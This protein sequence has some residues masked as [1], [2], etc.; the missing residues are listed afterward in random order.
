MHYNSHLKNLVSALPHEPGIYQY[1]DKDGTIIYIGK[2][3]DLKKRVS[4]YFTKTHD[5]RKTA[6]LVRNIIDIKTIVVETEQ[7]A[8]I[9]ENNLIKKYKPRYNIM[10][11]DDKTY[12]WIC[13]KNESF[14]RVFQTRRIERD[15]SLYFGPFTSVMLVR[16]L[17]ELFRQSYKLRNC[18]LQLSEANVS[19]GKFKV[20]LQ[21]HIGNCLGP[22]ENYQNE[23]SYNK[24]I[25]EIKSIL[26]GNIGSVI[27]GL[28]TAMKKYSEE[29]NFEEA[30]QIKLRLEILQN[31]QAK[32][33]VVSPT[34]QNVDVY[35]FL[36]DDQTIYINFLK[37]VRGSVIHSFTLEIKEKVEENDEDIL[38]F[39]ITEIRQRIF[40]NAT[41]FIVPFK[42]SFQ[43]E[44]IKFTIPQRGDKK[45]LLELSEKNVKYY[46][47]ETKKNN[48]LLK[49]E[50]PSERILKTA[51]KD[52]GLKEL[53]FHIEC[54]DNSNL[55]GT[56]PVA[57]CV[58]FKN[59]K[60][61]KK[62]YRHFNIK[63]VDGPNDFASMEEIVFRRY[64][65]LLDENQ[66]LPN[67][68]IVDGGKGQLGSA[69]NALEKLGLRGKLPIIGIA[70]RLE[71]IYYPG[72]PVPLYID[73]TSE[74]LKL[75]QQ[76]RDEA[77]RFGIT[78]HR[79]KRS[80]AMIVS[81]LDQ[82]KGVGEKT[83]ELLLRQYKSIE[84]I[85][86]AD[87]VEV[88]NLIGKSKA[89]LLKEYFSKEI[90]KL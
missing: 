73:K 40:S 69:M 76:M 44:G 85:R 57:S 74:T 87:F 27:S 34:I 64:R 10:L 41:E 53:P 14:P 54:F 3:K 25:E 90:S 62:E 48:S 19:R 51:Q 68:I 11:K 43:L 79:D 23:E 39:G 28:K 58:V 9:L 70:K 16:T 66:H 78:H 71:E 81:E 33:T 86:T 35:S 42:P 24:S 83:K 72:D 20:C 45:M 84:N 32:S 1:F 18:N 46:V 80:K 31:Y 65:R 8:L 52:L 17:L 36:R 88:E 47:L 63:T 2:A 12:P 37:V 21:Y 15:G 26:K 13:I 60:P 22:C 75:I 89:V 38:L 4:S 59:A 56:N 7:D 67:L 61:A 55:Q 50:K 5:N 30:Q 29:L 77:H 82:I 49:N 6:I